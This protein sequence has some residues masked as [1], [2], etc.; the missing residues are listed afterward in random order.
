MVQAIRYVS[1][2]IIGKNYYPYTQYLHEDQD[3]CRSRSPC[4]C[5]LLAETNHFGLGAVLLLCL[6]SE[7]Q[8]LLSQGLEPRALFR[9]LDFSKISSW[10]QDVIMPIL[11]QIGVFD[12]EI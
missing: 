6:V 5:N 10:Y 1:Q 11:G 8:K 9:R 2:N 7:L 4:S 3:N 12:L